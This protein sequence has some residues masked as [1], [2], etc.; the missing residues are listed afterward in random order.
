M[1]Q[2]CINSFV[3]RLDNDFYVRE[4]NKTKIPQ[5]HKQLGKK[6]RERQ[7]SKKDYAEIT[8]KFFDIFYNELYFFN[9]PSYFFLGGFVEKKRTKPGVRRR[10]PGK[11]SEREKIYV[12]FP[13]S[14]S[15]TDLF[16]LNQ[17][18][19]QISYKKIKGQ[20]RPTNIIERNWRRTNN[21]YDL[22]EV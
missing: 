13:I 15:W 22:D 6:I 7:I 17:K 2:S 18:E 20:T 10:G 5:R 4:F 21:F 11:G 14:I 16:F 8:A 12:E 3:E 1:S 9:K 19:G